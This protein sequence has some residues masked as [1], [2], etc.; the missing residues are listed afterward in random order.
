MKQFQ[1]LIGRLRTERL[2]EY[3]RLEKESFNPLQVGSEQESGLW[4]EYLKEVSIPYRQAQN[5]LLQSY[6]PVEIFRFNPL[7]VGSE[8]VLIE[9]SEI[10]KI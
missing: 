7:Q 10:R 2:D 9:F 3:T 8:Q 4:K 5:L 1:S 6:I